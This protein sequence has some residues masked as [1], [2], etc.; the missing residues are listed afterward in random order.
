MLFVVSF[1]RFYISFLF[2]IF[3]VGVFHYYFSFFLFNVGISWVWRHSLVANLCFSCCFICWFWVHF[4]PSIAV[5]ILF[6]VGEFL[7]ICATNVY[8]FS[9][10][11]YLHRYVFLATTVEVFYFLDTLSLRKEEEEEVE[12]GWR[13]EGGM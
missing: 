10:T 11:S 7:K 2:N 13:G 5:G 1:L 4:L 9:V 12:G 8:H 6:W 3:I